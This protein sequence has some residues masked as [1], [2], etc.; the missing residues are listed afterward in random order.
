[1]LLEVAVGL[2]PLVG[3]SAD[4]LGAAMGVSVL[5][6]ELSPEE[7]LLCAVA[8]LIPV[9]AGSALAEGASVSRAALLTGRGLQEAQVL[10]RVAQHLTPGDGERVRRLLRLAG[11]G[12]KVPAE[13]LQWMHALTQRLRGPLAEVAAA[14]KSG[15]RVPLLGSRATAEGMRLVPGS[16]EHLA[17]AW[18]D[19][20]FRHPGKYPHFEFAPDS[21]WERMY[22][23][24]LENK[25][26][27]GE[28]EQQVLKARGYEKNTAMMLPPPGSQVDQGFIP[29]SVV[30]S[31]EELVWG[32]PYRFVEVKGR[33]EMS[34][35]GN[36]KAMI[37]YVK[38]YGGHLEVCFRSARHAQGQTMLTDTLVRELR[39]LSRNHQAQVQWYP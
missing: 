10:Q 19:Y 39:F 33:A 24:V 2:L 20:Q 15:A 16:A 6:R 9:V 12:K 28:F 37:T 34:L 11:Q 36:L 29:D 5:G 22:R 17:Q 21:T 14:V 3:E 27:G 26:R 7:R 8:V 18:V 4:L 23:T 31:P 38:R 1:V 25:G 32:R 13:E 30:G 35:T